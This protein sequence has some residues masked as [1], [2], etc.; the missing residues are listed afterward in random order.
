MKTYTIPESERENVLK[1]LARYQK[2]GNSLW[3]QSD[4]ELANPMPPSGT[5]TKR[6]HRLYHETFSH[7]KVGEQMIEVFDLSIEGEI[8][9]NSNYS[10]V[11]KIEHLDGGN[12]VAAFLPDDRIRHGR[13]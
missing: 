5:S 12:I 1:I 8:I 9:R 11:A 13:S 6:V 4:R 7:S 3:N 2:E 10:V